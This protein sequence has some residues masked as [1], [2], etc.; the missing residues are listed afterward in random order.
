MKNIQAYWILIPLAAGTLAVGCKPADR[1]GDTSPPENSAIT[2][3]DP[4]RETGNMANLPPLTHDQ[5]DIFVSN[6]ELQLSILNR[7]IDELSAK[8]E[9]SSS[10]VQEEGEPRIEELRAQASRLG[11]KLDTVRGAS[12]S[13]WDSVKTGT[14]QAYD[15][16]KVALGNTRDW[17]SDQIDP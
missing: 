15:D 13:T 4:A 10:A 12:E 8:I 6:L 9:N 14:G 1:T 3:T 16:L 17:I 5:K 7:N 11:E 2:Q